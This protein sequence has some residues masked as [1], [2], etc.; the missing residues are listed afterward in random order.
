MLTLTRGS[1]ELGG[2]VAFMGFCVTSFTMAM[3]AGSVPAG[4]IGDRYGTAR[5]LAVN[6]ALTALAC[7]ACAFAPGAWTFLFAYTL[8]GLA[9]GTFHPAA[10]GLLSLSV[11]SERLGRAMGAFGVAG[12]IG[13]ASMP[14]LM[15]ET[16]G[17][18]YGFGIM[19]S[20][21]ALALV[22]TVTLIRRGVLLPGV[23]PPEAAPSA[24]A[25]SPARRSS[26]VVLLMVMGVSG[27]LHAGFMVLA[28][29]TVKG[30]GGYIVSQSA[31]MS[32]ILL[33]GAI[34]QWVGGHIA[35][36]TSRGG[37]YVFLLAWQPVLLFA[38]ALNLG[39]QGMGFALMGSFAFLNTMLQPVENRLLTT[40]TSR[41]RR[42]TGYA[43]KFV[44]SLAIAAPA[45]KLLGELLEV[46]WSYSAMWKLLASVGALAAI[47][48]LVFTRLMRRAPRT[49]SS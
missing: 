3:A 12:S 41:A 47:G 23:P 29:E 43:L 6:F 44:V 36:E 22:A 37:R 2:D 16:L 7:L 25:F 19:A 30:D 13:M 48:G 49:E 45:G 39:S 31:L 17:W 26:L 38:V 5:V 24:V 42:S 33:L 40:F 35:R 18:R 28:P 34:G 11:P 20:V 32:S 14:L 10:L 46:P 1:Q 21:A 8:L 4:M 9:A 15:S 27:F